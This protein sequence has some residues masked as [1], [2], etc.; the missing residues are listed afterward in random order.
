MDLLPPR[1]VPCGFLFEPNAKFSLGTF[2]E[3]FSL[4]LQCELNSFLVIFIFFQLFS[5]SQSD[6]PR[7]PLEFL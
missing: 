6:A 7:S 2:C 5:P 4:E 3:I 1:A